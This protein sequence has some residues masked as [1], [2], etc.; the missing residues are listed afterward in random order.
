[1][2]NPLCTTSQTGGLGS[3]DL[4]RLRALLALTDIELDSLAFFER[5]VAVHFDCRPMHEDVAPIAVNRDEAEALFSVE[6]L[7]GSLR[8]GVSFVRFSLYF[9][10]ERVRTTLYGPW[11]TTV[12]KI[13]LLWRLHPVN[14]QNVM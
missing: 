2:V 1:M 14:Q 6:P 12:T 4:F 3:A 10:L 9:A 5:T 13:T 11:L 8:H 7:N